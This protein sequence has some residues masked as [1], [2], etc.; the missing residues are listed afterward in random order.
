M[1]ENKLIIASAGSGKTTLLAKLASERTNESILILTYTEANQAEIRKKLIAEKGCIPKHI[2]VQTWFSFLLQHGVRPYQSVLCEELHDE[3][4]G[5]LLTSEKSGKIFDEEGD[6]ILNA[7]GYPLVF[8][9][10]KNFKRHY[11]TTDF[12]I[13]SDKISKFVCATNKATDGE[14]IS[15]ITRIFSHIYIDEVQ[16]LAGFDLELVKLLLKAQASVLLAGDPRQVTY[17]THHSTKYGKYSDGKIKEFIQN[18][19]GKRIQCNIDEETLKASHRNNQLICDYSAKLYPKLPTPKACEC[20][21]CRKNT[22]THEGVFLIKPSDAGEYLTKFSTPPMQLRWDAR[23]K[24]T[25]AYPARNFGDSKGTTFERVLIFPT[26]DMRE[27]IRNNDT[28]LK[29]MTRAKLYVAL[30]RPRHSAT[31]V[32]DFED[33]ESFEGLEKYSG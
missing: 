30:T 16:D 28:D 10:E 29:N 21:K 14:V 7:A 11:F 22:S 1:V 26:E 4:I 2:T 6:P 19:L 33:S 9:E 24:C 13:Y 12:R 25:P 8:T 23:S 3:S 27:W 20:E 5:F 18:E 31:I 15:R 17:L 32:M